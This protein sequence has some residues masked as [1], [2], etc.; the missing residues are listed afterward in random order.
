MLDMALYDVMYFA[1]LLYDM[2]VNSP[3]GC[4]KSHPHP[5]LPPSLPPFYVDYNSAVQRH[6]RRMSRLKKMKRKSY[7]NTRGYIVTP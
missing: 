2:R 1:F 4:V 6:A 3:P 7:E 5:H